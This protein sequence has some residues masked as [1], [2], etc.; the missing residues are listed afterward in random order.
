MNGARKPW[1]QTLHEVGARVEDDLKRL[2]NYIND[3]VVPDVRKNGSEALKA[4]AAE[5]HRLA[6][7]MDDRRAPPPPPPPRTPGSGS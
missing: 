7:K 1:E 4:A 6:E 2:V 3:E 5:L